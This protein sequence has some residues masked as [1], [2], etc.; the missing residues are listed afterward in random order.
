M[1]RTLLMAIDI[2]TQS[3]RAALLTPDGAVVASA[4]RS[5]EMQTPQVGWAEQDPAMWWSNAVDCVQEA[6]ARAAAAPDEVLAVGVSGQMH[7]AVPLGASGDVL[8]NRVQL[9]CDKRCAALVDQFKHLPFAE[10]QLPQDRQSARGQ[11][12]RLQDQVAQ[13]IRS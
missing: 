7:G 1:K 2:G 12:D 11:L 8:S 9:W 4:V 5:Q 10:G 6:M 13:A 3:T